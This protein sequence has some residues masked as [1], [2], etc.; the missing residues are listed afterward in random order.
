MLRHH[1]PLLAYAL[2]APAALGRSEFR[3]L[4]YRGA[5]LG[6]SVTR[7]AGLGLLG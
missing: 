3:L 2:L 7:S 1:N 6:V 4:D 5:L